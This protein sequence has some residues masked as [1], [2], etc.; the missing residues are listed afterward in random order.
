LYSKYY[1]SFNCFKDAI[2][3]VVDKGHVI[4]ENELKTHVTQN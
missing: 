1:E 3:N 2:T 4:H